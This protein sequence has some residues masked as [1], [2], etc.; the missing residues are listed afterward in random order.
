[1]GTIAHPRWVSQVLRLM[2]QGLLAVLDAWSHGLALKRAEE[3]RQAGR[4][5][6][7]SK[8]AESKPA[9]PPY[10]LRPWRD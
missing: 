9:A 1:M 5:Q 4:G 8:P 6:A 2:P 3:R 7:E 10:K